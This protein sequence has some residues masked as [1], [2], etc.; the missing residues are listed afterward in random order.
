[1]PPTSKTRR[2]SNHAPAKDAFRV[3][4]TKDAFAAAEPEKHRY[5]KQ[6]CVTDTRGFATPR[7]LSPTRLVVDASEGF[8]P[9]W[10]EGVTLRWRFNAPSM[11]YFENPSEAE[12]G[13]EALLGAALMKWGEAAPVKFAKRDDAWDFEITMQKDDDCD[14]G[15]C[16]LAEAFFPDGGRHQLFLYPK[17]FVQDDTE[18]V[19]TLIHEIGHVFGLRHFFAKV[20]EK[21]WPAEIFGKHSKFSIMNYGEDSKL[22]SAD[23]KD[24]KTLYH[25]VWNGDLKDINGTRIVQVRPYHELGSK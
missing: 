1:M 23:R 7:N 5:R 8:I 25:G 15:G 6:L 22:T 19:E 9:L 18:Q 10:K 16:V 24:L 13:I 4:A 3:R 17:L 12:A 20:E 14:G 11:T 2:G 21:K